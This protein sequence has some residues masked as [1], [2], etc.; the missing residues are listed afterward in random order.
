MLLSLGPEDCLWP[1][2]AWRPFQNGRSCRLPDRGLRLGPCE[3][4]GPAQP[5]ERSGA[6]SGPSPPCWPAWVAHLPP[7]HVVI[8]EVTYQ[9][10]CK[11][12]TL[13]LY[14]EP[15]LQRGSQPSVS[16]RLHLP[17]PSS[18]SMAHLSLASTQKELI[19]I[20]Y[21]TGASRRGAA[22]FIMPRVPCLCST[23][24]L[25]S[26]KEHSLTRKGNCAAC[27]LAPVV[28]GCAL[29]IVHLQ[30][31]PVLLLAN[32]WSGNI[33]FAGFFFTLF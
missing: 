27:D 26:V 11:L 17:A 8:I 6:L 12:S 30:N 21:L 1:L 10:I 5:Q 24:C 20:V 13:Y 25:S 15:I 31:T 18:V 9:Q 3:P 28:W 7:L 32:S 33:K 2:P 14:R 19:T 22:R 23:Y 4:P 29:C 16:R